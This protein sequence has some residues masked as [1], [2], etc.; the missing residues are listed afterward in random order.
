MN[1]IGDNL[2][3]TGSNR[4]IVKALVEFEVNFI[5]AGGLAVSWYCSDRQADDMDLM[6]QPSVN[7]SYR[8]VSALETIGLK[9]PDSSGFSKLGVQA[10]LKQHHY[11]DLITPPKGGPS[12]EELFSNAEDGKL[13]DFPVRIVG[14]K[15]LIKL[16]EFAAKEEPE[17][18]KHQDDIRRLK[19]SAN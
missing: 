17:Q 5:V 2:V 15:S 14:R 4:E 7:N 3:C 9:P 18:Q 6:I 10:K 11:A 19:A 13:F 12:F 16:K 8:T 1:R